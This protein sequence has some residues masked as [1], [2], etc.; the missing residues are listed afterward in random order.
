MMSKK[1]EKNK[2]NEFDDSFL[3]LI[4]Y[5]ILNEAKYLIDEK[6]EDAWVDKISKWKDIGKV[7]IVC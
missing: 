1:H 7:I 4:E 6:I 3:N 2:D 5:K